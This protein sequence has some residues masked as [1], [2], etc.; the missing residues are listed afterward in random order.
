MNT[1]NR[2]LILIATTTLALTATAAFVFQTDA[3]NNLKIDFN[4]L[5]KENKI[6]K[7]N[8][9]E[10]AIIIDQLIEEIEIKED[11]ISGLLIT[12]DG[13][14]AEINVLKEK[15]RSKNQKVQKLSSS[16]TELTR[17]I[18]QL[19]NGNSADQ[20]LIKELA[21]ERNELLDKMLT[22]DRE[23]E[24]EK[25][26]IKIKE[27]AV[28]ETNHNIED[29]ESSVDLDKE[30]IQSNNQSLSINNEPFPAGTPAPMAIDKEM[31]VLIKTRKQARMTEIVSNTKVNFT[32]IALRDQKEGKDFSKINNDGWRYTLI[33][34]DLVHPNPEVILDE[35]FILQVFDVD[36]QKVV[37]VNE[38]N[39]G[40]PDS[41]IGSTGYRFIYE[42]QPLSVTYFN[43]QKKTGKNYEI[44]LY[45]AGKGFLI[46]L[47]NGSTRI[48]SDGAV[49]VR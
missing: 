32:S 19:K 8:I 27:A 38:S 21:D 7:K 34:F 45:Y 9:Q 18:S 48:M 20:K 46:P 25:N 28:A 16:V 17:E 35:A 42:G 26:R 14:V 23:R 39:P 37:P 43:S 47:P 41:K 3:Y 49:A 30:R 33:D 13:L 11:S 40:F 31:E 12:I 24:K 44:R 6:N 4:L 15:V 29:L 10:Q 1:L 36:N 2:R 5:L 22:L